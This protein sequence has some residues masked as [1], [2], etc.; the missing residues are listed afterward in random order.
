MC[1][2]E[3][4]AIFGIYIIN[5]MNSKSLFWI[6][7]VLIVIKLVKSDIEYP[8]SGDDEANILPGDFSINKGRV[9]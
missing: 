1:F 6:Q 5:N 9:A 2:W 8:I 7:I 3:E 4:E